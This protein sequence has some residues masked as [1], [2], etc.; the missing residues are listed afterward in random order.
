MLG[1]E[2]YATKLKNWRHSITSADSCYNET[3]KKKKIKESMNQ[4]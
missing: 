2:L 1:L 3:G 4:N